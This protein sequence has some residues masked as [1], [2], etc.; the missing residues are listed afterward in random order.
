MV[1]Y[2]NGKELILNYIENIHNWQFVIY[3]LFYMLFF[4]KI[5]YLEIF[6]FNSVEILI[7]LNYV[8]Y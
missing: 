7:S 8:Y 4:I 2:S 6:L 5:I 1:K 3:I